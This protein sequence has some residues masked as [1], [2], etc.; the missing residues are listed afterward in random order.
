MTYHWKSKQETLREVVGEIKITNLTQNKVE[1][2]YSLARK[3]K[4]YGKEEPTI[5]NFPTEFYNAIHKAI[6]SIP[7]SQSIIQCVSYKINDWGSK[8]NIPDLNSL[9]IQLMYR[10]V[11]VKI[12]HQSNSA[13]KLVIYCKPDEIEHILPILKFY[14][15]TVVHI[16][17]NKKYYC[18]ASYNSDSHIRQRLHEDIAS[19]KI[20]RYPKVT[21]RKIFRM[22]VHSPDSSPVGQIV[23]QNH[24]LPKVRYCL[25][26]TGCLNW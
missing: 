21:V 6:E 7:N 11:G 3:Q 19:A 18:F 22:L 24:I 1:Q 9:L 10:K 13:L 8:R 15:L 5:Y 20:L 26:K 4:L 16:G 23:Q 17:K 14:D 12:T 2:F 25:H